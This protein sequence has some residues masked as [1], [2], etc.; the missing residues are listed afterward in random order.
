MA[1]DSST[2]PMD[3]SATAENELSKSEDQ[4]N[5]SNG[6]SE[7]TLSHSNGA[8]EDSVEELMRSTLVHRGAL[9][10]GSV[11]NLA[12]G[13]LGGG[14]D[15][16][17]IHKPSHHVP[18][19]SDF[20]SSQPDKL[21]KT[22]FS[23]SG[24]SSEPAE[25]VTSLLE[26]TVLAYGEHT[27]LAV[28]RQGEWQKWTYRKYQ[29]ECMCMAKAMIE[30][31]LEPHHG[32]CILGFNSPEW[33]I[34]CLAAIMAGGLSVGLYLTSTADACHNAALICKANIIIL[35][36]DTQLQKI[37]RIRD[38]LPDLKAIIQYTKEVREPTNSVF[39][40]RQAMNLGSRTSEARLRQRMDVLQ[41]N[42]CCS[43]IFT[44]GTSGKSKG[45]MLSH[46]N[47]TWMCRRILSYVNFT[48]GEEHMISY[49]P[50]S[51]V[52]PQLLDV[53]LPI[54]TAGTCWFAQPDA[55]KGSLL[56]TMKEVRPTIFLGVPRV[57]EKIAESMQLVSMNTSGFKAKVASWA[58]GLGLK[59]NLRKQS[60][61]K[62]SKPFGW[63]LAS[64]F[65]FK[66]V[67]EALGLDR[68]H[69]PMTGAAPTN[70]DTLSYFMSVDIPLHELYGMSET[71]GPTTVTTTDRIR[72]CSVGRKFEGGEIKIDR[73][74]KEGT[75]EVLL[76][77]RH[78]F[79]GYL[80]LPELT[81]NTLTHDGWLR[82][83]DIG[84]V[85]EDGYLY[86]TGRKKELIITAGGEK[87]APV[88]I[89]SL[90]KQALPM[91]S[92]AILI[93]DQRKFLTCL[94]TLKV[95]VDNTTGLPT[96]RLTPAAL[97]CCQKVG[98]SSATV[99]DII[100]RGEG[101]H[102]V[103]RMIQKAVDN[104]NKKASSKISKIAKWSILD[105]DFSIAGGELTPTLKLKR[106]VIMM[107][108]AD[109]I[110]AFYLT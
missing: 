69:F 4:L 68:C 58:K 44:S 92:N 3:D 43:V 77:G 41:P 24:A 56:N 80:G 11:D 40:W 62:S 6:A 90:I 26:R 51:H 67:R 28:K 88:P 46:D 83:G 64:M 49:L 59:A 93:G 22:R 27:A 70:E 14:E 73:P 47:L 31:G 30:L 85:S 79:M 108:Y 106:S 94:L 66:K 78:V 5:Q 35:E 50:L 42:K 74:D 18:L 37:L 20:W 105:N 99:G 110:D 23:E 17:S 103:L 71:S 91:V 95:E 89:E 38:Q 96:D 100:D 102:K 87:V 1:E 97:A 84:Y 55:L 61:D 15:G 81:Q 21:V 13:L 54:A 57:W 86:I 52:A 75:G 101:D 25:T 8:S 9:E 10:M 109:C 29:E 72:Y 33:H 53:Y 63:S 107:K 65:F 32:V 104:V 16:F 60:G 82:S 76:R 2:S 39:D 45:V 19:H 48:S 12:D 36:N 34:S 7:D 98:S